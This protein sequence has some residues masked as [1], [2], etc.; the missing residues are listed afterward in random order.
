MKILLIL[1]TI[2]SIDFSSQT[3]AWGFKDDFQNDLCHVQ[4]IDAASKQ[5]KNGDVFLFRPQ[6]WGNEQAPIVLSAIFCN[7]EHPII[8]NVAGV[9]CIFTDARKK[10][11]SSFGIGMDK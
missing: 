5:C 2:A 3:F 6:S 11:W 8:Y 1:I 4:N 10:S 7:Y 9:S